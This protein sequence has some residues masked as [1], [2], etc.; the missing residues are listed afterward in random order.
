MIICKSCKSY[1]IQYY[2]TLISN[3]LRRPRNATN[4]SNL[5]KAAFCSEFITHGISDIS[6]FCYM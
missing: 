4:P 1:L 2:I 3:Y 6:V 5:T